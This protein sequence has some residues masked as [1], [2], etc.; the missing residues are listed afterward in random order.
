MKY[1]FVSIDLHDLQEF[2]VL[3][4]CVKGENAFLEETNFTKA[5]RG[6]CA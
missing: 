1:R 6:C 4:N 3:I 2:E 5:V